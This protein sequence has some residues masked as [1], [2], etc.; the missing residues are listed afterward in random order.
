MHYE[1]INH[2]VI[3]VGT[4]SVYADTSLYLVVLVHY[5]LALLGT[6]WYRVSI[7][8]LCLYIFST[9][10]IYYENKIRIVGLTSNRNCMQASRNSLYIFW[11]KV[12]ISL[13][14]TD[15]LFTHSLTDRQQIIKLLSLFTVKSQSWVTQLTCQLSLYLAPHTIIFSMHDLNIFSGS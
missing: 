13:G 14:V 4:G 15:V 2:T 12:E 3:P 1:L 9:G 7:G 10:P 8:L 5:K 11:K 6:W